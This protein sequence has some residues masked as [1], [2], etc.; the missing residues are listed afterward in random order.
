[1]DIHRFSSRDQI[2]ADLTPLNGVGNGPILY[3]EHGTHYQ[4]VSQGHTLVVGRSGAGKTTSVTQTAVCGALMAGT[5]TVVLD[6]KGNVY[7]ATRGLAEQQDYQC[8]C[9]DLSRP[10]SSPASMNPLTTIYE[11]LSSGNPL[12]ASWACEDINELA[13]ALV[14]R[15]DKDPYWHFAG[16]ELIS[17]VIHLLCTEG[18]ADEINLASVLRILTEANTPVAQSTNLKQFFEFSKSESLAKRFLTTYANAPKDT[19]ASIFSVANTSIGKLI[20]SPLM[21]D[22]LSADSFRLA[23][24]DLARPF[25]IWIIVPDESVSTYIPLAAA[26]LAQIIRW[27]LRAARHCYGGTLPIPVTAVMEELGSMGRCLPQL[28]ELVS[29]SRSRGLNM[30]LC[31]QSLA[32]LDLLYGADSAAV[33]RDNMETIIAFAG[34]DPA[35]LEQL[36]AS[37]GS[38]QVRT[39]AGASLRPVIMPGRLAAMGVGQ[40]LVQ[41]PGGVQYITRLPRF[42]EAYALPEPV[43]ETVRRRASYRVFSLDE[44]IRRKRK[45]HLDALLNKDSFP[46]ILKEGELNEQK[47]WSAQDKPSRRDRFATNPALLSVDTDPISAEKERRRDSWKRPAPLNTWK[48]GKR[49]D[50]QDSR[51]DEEDH[52]PEL[53]LE[54]FS[55]LL[56]MK[57]QYMRCRREETSS[58]RDRKEN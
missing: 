53:D 57:E 47:R 27:L 19:A 37:C 58:G 34:K 11:N 2:L 16:V 23:D 17:G 4:S 43:P 21:E 50:G 12:K 20:P 44:Y 33:I 5:S 6:A 35:G 22:F 41:R 1:M 3:S 49:D 13:Q 56:E 14:P 30:I 18:K 45:E 46:P 26:I 48:P 55:V 8:F 24:I 28:P 25:A 38:F 15:D 39:H 42:N 29:T 52:F 32:Q 40:V 10:L 36:A 9:V 54:D 51:T 7:E 31:L